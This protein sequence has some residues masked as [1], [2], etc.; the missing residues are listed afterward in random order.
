MDKT[1][2]GVEMRD[3]VWEN[4]SQDE[5]RCK[6]SDMLIV[7]AKFMNALQTLR[8]EF[9]RP[10]R[11]TSACR[12]AAHNNSVGGHPKSL[13]VCDEPA[14]RSEDGGCLAVD[15]AIVDGGYR[16]HLVSTAWRLGWSV[17][18][19]KRFVHLDRRDFLFDPK[20]QTTFDY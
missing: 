5:M 19:N 15:V 18:W 7:S 13:H 4:F 20:K 10:M 16:G 1:Q 11:L 14:H 2:T 17:G 6:G 9:S 3:W 8:E 12:S